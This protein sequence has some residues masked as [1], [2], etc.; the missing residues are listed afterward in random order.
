MAKGFG[1]SVL[2][3]TGRDANPFA[4]AAV[5]GRRVWRQVGGLLLLQMLLQ[6]LLL[7]DL[8][9][10]LQLLLLKLDLELLVLL[11]IL[12][13]V[14]RRFLL[15]QGRPPLQVLASQMIELAEERPLPAVLLGL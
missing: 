4:L 10:L 5:T 7:L 13:M 2:A 14:L 1:P 6:E 12:Q 3:Q 11:Q 8:L 9:L 15:H